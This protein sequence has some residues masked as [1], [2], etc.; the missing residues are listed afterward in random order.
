MRQKF[1]LLF[2]FVLMILLYSC[3]K[4][5]LIRTVHWAESMSNIEMQNNELE[6]FYLFHYIEVADTGDIK[7]MMH[8]KTDSNSESFKIKLTESL[9][10]EILTLASQDSIYC[11]PQKDLDQTIVYSGLTY[12]LHF[13][14]DTTNRSVTFIKPMTFQHHKRLISIMD[15][16]FKN[17][18]VL[19]TIHMDLQ[20][21][22][23]QIKDKIPEN[24]QSPSRNKIKFAPPK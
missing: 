19:D 21:I 13:V 11:F 12:H 9:K 16:I 24:Y 7:V 3:K 4:E 2:I 22:E 15:S 20:Q 14:C 8:K 10:N 23:R 18:V 1:L 6:P 5:R 17:P